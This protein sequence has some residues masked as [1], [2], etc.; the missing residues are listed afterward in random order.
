MLIGC[1]VELTETAES[2]DNSLSLSQQVTHL[3]KKGGIRAA[4]NLDLVSM[5]FDLRTNKST[6]T[7]N[8]FLAG[9]LI[10]NTTY[11]REKKLSVNQACS[12]SPEV[13]RLSSVGCGMLT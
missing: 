4:L 6:L 9:Q 10:N 2:G 7:D 13:T 5:H 1:S 8:L 12:P 3:V 11:G